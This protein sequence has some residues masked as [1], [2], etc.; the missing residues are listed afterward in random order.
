[1]I[2]VSDTSPLNYLILINAID[3]L[4]MLFEEIYVPARVME[5]LERLCA[6]IGETMVSKPTALAPCEHAIDDRCNVGSRRSWRS[7]CYRFSEG[8]AGGRNSH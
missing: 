6:R 2:V 3:V 5:E 4:P 8:A 7:R 1:M